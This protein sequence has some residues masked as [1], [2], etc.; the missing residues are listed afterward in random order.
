MGK[1]IDLLLARDKLGHGLSFNYKGNESH[2]TKLG[3]F[4][5]IAIQAMTLIYLG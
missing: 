5:S 4:F 3:A 2:P 1:L